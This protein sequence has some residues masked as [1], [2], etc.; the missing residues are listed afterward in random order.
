MSKKIPRWTNVREFSPDQ[1]SEESYIRNDSIQ[2][3]SIVENGDQTVSVLAHALGGVYLIT[4]VDNYQEAK[5]QLE[6]VVQEI[7]A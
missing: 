2:R 7:A 1:K 5:K 6:S 4:T 3:L